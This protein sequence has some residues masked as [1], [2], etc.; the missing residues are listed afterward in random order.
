[1]D[2]PPRQRPRVEHV[3][4]VASVVPPGRVDALPVPPAPLAADGGAQ[5]VFPSDVSMT[6]QVLISTMLHSFNAGK[7]KDDPPEQ[8]LWAF[9]PGT[10]FRTPSNPKASERFLYPHLYVSQ[11]ASEHDNRMSLYRTDLNSFLNIYPYD[12]ISTT[13]RRVINRL[14]NQ[15]DIWLRM[16]INTQPSK[17]DW[18][19]LYQINNLL[20]F[21]LAVAKAGVDSVDYIDKVLDDQWDQMDLNYVRLLS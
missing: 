6:P 13:G 17:D 7:S 10:T 9:I 15:I 8:R 12:H 19:L 4:A 1:M 11:N 16:H 21:Q 3:P 5:I 18:E 2:Q 20:V 14:V